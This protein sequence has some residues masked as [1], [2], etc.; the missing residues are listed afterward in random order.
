MRCLY[1]VFEVAED[2]FE[3]HERF[4]GA[5]V[6]GEVGVD[7]AVVPVFGAHGIGVVAGGHVAPVANK[8]L[9]AGGENLLAHGV[10]I[11]LAGSLHGI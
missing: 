1:S 10:E 6:G 3:V 4:V 8:L 7:I 2:V 9:V 5:S 11:V